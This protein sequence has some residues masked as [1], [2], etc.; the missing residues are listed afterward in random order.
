VVV[1]IAAGGFEILF[2]LL[3]IPAQTRPLAAWGIILMLIAFLPVHV[4]ML[5]NAPLMVGHT[6]VTPTLAW[7]RLLFQPVLML[8]AWWHSREW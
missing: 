3:L 5:S 6:L 4:S 7:L 1:N 2:A 8:W